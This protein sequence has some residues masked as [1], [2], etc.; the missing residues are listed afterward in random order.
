[1]AIVDAH[2][3]LNE[4][5]DDWVRITKDQRE[6]LEAARNACLDR[7]SRGLEQLGDQRNQNFQTFAS[8][9][10]QGSFAMGTLNQHP[11]GESDIDI[12]VI[13]RKEHL[14]TTAL[15]ARKRV[16][17]AL[18]IA[19]GNFVRPPEARTNAVTVWYADG[20]HVD[21]AVYRQVERFLGSELQH[22]GPE[23]RV[24]DPTIV[25]NWFTKTVDELSPEL[26]IAVREHQF[27]RIV[28]WV[29]MFARSRVRW[30]LPGGM[31]L[32]ALLAETYRLD[33]KRDD[34]SL[35]ATLQA[36]VERL[37]RSLV[38]MNP[39][40]GSHELTGK[41][42]RLAQMKDLQAVLVEAFDDLSVLK[43]RGCSR[44]K[45]LRAWGTFFNHPYWRERAANKPQ[46]RA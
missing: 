32:T 4:F 38:V 27:R 46:Q 31:I 13:F 36:T 37:E 33:R 20:A 24:L 45:A 11:R 19:G 41:P 17:D 8:F 35:Y 3:E 9:I 21:F 42:T 5:Y 7:L 29:K 28:Q 44:K 43:E 30:D 34:V 1:V 15:A 22:A 39:I 23:W 6:R 16:A 12:A 14:P 40:D 26:F 18:L 25:T 2:T 10:E